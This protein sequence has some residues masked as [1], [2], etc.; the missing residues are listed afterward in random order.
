MKATLRCVLLVASL[1][2]GIQWA[3]A[4][5]NPIPAFAGRVTDTSGTLSVAETEALDKK[6]AEFDSSTGAQMRVLMVRNLGG[7]S[8]ESFAQR[9]YEE[10]RPSLASDNKGILLVLSRH[11][12][13][14]RFQVGKGLESAISA[15]V[16]RQALDAAKPF[17]KKEQYAQGF[18]AAVDV[19]AAQLAPV[20]GGPLPPVA[21]PG[22]STATSASDSGDSFLPFLALG[23]VVI[24]L[25]AV[26][27]LFGIRTRRAKARLAEEAAKKERELQREIARDYANSVHAKLASR[28]TEKQAE[29][30]AKTPGGYTTRN[31]PA[32]RPRVGPAPAPAPS[33]LSPV[34]SSV[35]SRRDDDNRR[36]DTNYL[37]L[38]AAAML[39][40]ASSSAPAE[41]PRAPAPAP[42]PAP[43]PSYSSSSSS[44][45]DSYSSGSSWSSSSSSSSSSSYSSSDYSSSSSSSSSGDY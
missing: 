6:L 35:A 36:D 31:A 37:G 30:S 8:I 14:T 38:T 2:L 4:E 25:L 34:T 9:A 40:T 27:V 1:L 16:S 19:A 45:D 15:E 21:V 18:V 17:F 29:S 7:E 13:K 32:P 43:A 22:T 11:E 12:R 20:T 41:S 3:H 5:P 28:K 10:I 39:M 44:R 33:R 26:P 23:V 24:P 42:E